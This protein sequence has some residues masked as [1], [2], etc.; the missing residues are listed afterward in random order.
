MTHLHWGTRLTF[1]LAMAANIGCGG[2]ER[3]AV[4]GT[5]TVDG[6]PVEYGYIEYRPVEGTS[7]PTA[8]SAINQGEY[9][10]EATKGPFAGTFRV[11]IRATR[12]TDQMVADEI[13]GEEVAYHEQFLPE[14]F[15]VDS[16]LEVD[17]AANRERYDFNLSLAEE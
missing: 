16:Q 12:A 9:V 15:N 6:V 2:D 3:Q 8:G 17:I 14:Q 10:I 11:E 1:C 7:G 13:T 4:Q 5:V